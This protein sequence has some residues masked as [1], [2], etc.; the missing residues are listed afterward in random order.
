MTADVY[1]QLV[2]STCND[3]SLQWTLTADGHLQTGNQCL[4]VTTVNGGY[5]IRVA[6]CATTPG[7]TFARQDDKLV[8]RAYN[9]CLTSEGGYGGV[10][11]LDTCYAANMWYDFNT[12]SN[13]F[14]VSSTFVPLNPANS[15][16]W[17]AF[18]QPVIPP[19][20]PPI[21]PYYQ[22]L[23]NFL[24][25]TQ[26]REAWA[27]TG[28]YFPVGSPKVTLLSA[29]SGL[30]TAG[31]YGGIDGAIPVG[32]SHA[33][34]V[35]FILYACENDVSS[36][37]HYVL[38]C[39]KNVVKRAVDVNVTIPAMQALDFSNFNEMRQAMWGS[40]TPPQVYTASVANA[41]FY[42]DQATSVRVADL[43]FDADNVLAFTSQP[44]SYTNQDNTV[45]G[46]YYNALVIGPPE[47]LPSYGNSTID[48]TNN[49]P[50]SKPDLVVY[51]YNLAQAT[52]WSTPTAAAVGAGLLSIAKEHPAYA[53]GA[54]PLVIRAVLLAA[55][56]KFINYPGA[57]W[58]QNLPLQPLDAIYGAGELDVN[59][60]WKIYLAGPY[61]NAQNSL[62]WQSVSLAAGAQKQFRIP[63]AQA[64]ALSAVV[65]W[66]RKITVTG[67]GLLD[68]QLADL[69]LSVSDGSGHL[70]T[71]SDSAGSN[72]EHI[73]LPSTQAGDL[74]LTVTNKSANTIA[75]GI[76]WHR[77]ST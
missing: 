37:I 34:G 67:P 70:I 3:S 10:R 17:E 54:S 65:T 4:A 52:S 11:G 16:V 1:G 30:P 44:G 62:A 15:S 36:D 29:E 21:H 45:S 55:A 68:A 56:R 69:S 23:E 8:V 2:S 42:R 41:T 9:L 43:M 6:A 64:T 58:S 77:E 39:M 24:A 73:Y 20:Y 27:S 50:R 47:P 5:R 51:P 18:P 7:Q 33:D 49:A 46:N 35:A 72:V 48:N 12:P 38:G 32:D 60:T 66:N 71:T 25:D 75:A 74:L 26:Y 22:S 31:S 13:F 57:T 40:T 19:Q 28:G 63:G 14:F 59:A 61:P 53:S 76:A